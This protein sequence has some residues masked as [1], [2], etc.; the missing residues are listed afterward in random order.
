M[1]IIKKGK[2]F[3][4]KDQGETSP[5]KL[6]TW[7]V[8][9]FLLVMAFS[10]RLFLILQPEVIHND[11][12]AY[13]YQ[14][15]QILS[16]GNWAGGK[17][18]PLYPLLI[19][20]F[21][22]IT[23]NEELAGIWV[24]VIFGTLLVLPVFFLGK[25]IFNKSVGLIAALFAVVH[26][27]L[28]TASGSV[29]SESIYYFSMTTA[30]LFGWKT[31]RQGRFFQTI[32]F[33]LFTTLAYLTRPE[34]IGLIFIFAFWVLFISPPRQQRHWTRRMGIF[35]L[36]IFSFIVFSFPYLVQLKRET[37]R[38]G[39]SGKLSIS[40]GSLSEGE[41]VP[42]IDEIRKNREFPLLSLV[43]DPLTTIKKIVLGLFSSIY[44][45]QQALNPLLFLFALLAGIWKRNSPYTFKGDF[46][47]LSHF[48]FFFGLVLPFFWITRRYTSQLVPISLP[49][50]AF[51]FLGLINW[52]S[53]KL[54][55]G[56]LKK[57]ISVFLLSF[58]LMGLFVQGRV[59]HTRSHRFI[60]R[61]VG[62]WMKDRLPKGTK[63]MS[64]M[65]QEAFYAQQPWVRMPQGSY[66]EIIETARSN[67][68]Q[69]LV[70]DEK[71]EEDS[72]GFWEK[73]GQGNLIPLLDLRRKNRRMV[74]FQIGYP[75]GK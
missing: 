28:Y 19:A 57:R 33:T 35:F 34:G 24:S 1:K 45:F 49:W 74:V 50:A 48:I 59:I 9:L 75:Q 66:E 11:G 69:Y 27:L 40:M 71:I 20:L 67:G 23:P 8:L 16:E 53:P 41:R 32:L 73:I 10:L 63:V 25:E 14:A 72:P 13:I 46:Y 54:K 44:I 4:I 38:W 60:Q 51:G 61:E 55:E 65:P 26:P 22:F 42:S 31:F 68:V 70:I 47:L 29:L 17:A 56:K 15:R 21:H 43:N 18:P 39:I 36:A 6:R 12:I 58:I 7:K 5:E 62:L 3:D 2:E 64:S 37:G 30:V 52:I